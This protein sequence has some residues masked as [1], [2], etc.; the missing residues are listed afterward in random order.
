M[1]QIELEMQ[2]E[3]LKRAHV[4]LDESRDKYLDLYDFAPMGYFTLTRVGQIAEVN[5]G[6]KST[7]SG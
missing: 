5:L 4:S 3:E 2:N 1:H 6:S 7:S